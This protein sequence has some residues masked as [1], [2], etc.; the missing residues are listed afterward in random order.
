LPFLSFFAGLLIATDL[1]RLALPHY[2]NT[3]NFAHYS[4]RAN[5]FVPQFDARG[6]RAGCICQD[7]GDLFWR[8]RAN[9]R[10][11]WLSA[12]ARQ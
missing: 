5:R 2:P 7:Q 1:V 11:A 4:F 9:T 8:L 6:P 12:Q 3:P 10:Y